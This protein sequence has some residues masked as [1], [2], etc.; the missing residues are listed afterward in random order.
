[1]QPALA[2]LLGNAKIFDEKPAK[3]ITPEQLSDL[4][5]SEW[6]ISNLSIPDDAVTLAEVIDACRQER[7]EFLAKNEPLTPSSTTAPSEPA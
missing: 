6:G 4:L 3:S 5:L 2:T 7:T 1:M